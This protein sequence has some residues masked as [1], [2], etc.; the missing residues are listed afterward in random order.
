LALARAVAA[1]GRILLAPA[2]V[3]GA[4]ALRA[5]FVNHRTTEDDVRAIPAVLAD[6]A[7]LA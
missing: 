6:L 7:D 2:E 1:D 3:D 5:C 4:T